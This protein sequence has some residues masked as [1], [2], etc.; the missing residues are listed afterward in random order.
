VQQKSTM[1]QRKLET[2]LSK[3]NLPSMVSFLPCHFVSTFGMPPTFLMLTTNFRTSNLIEKKSKNSI[4]SW[5]VLLSSS[6]L[7]EDKNSDGP[8]RKI[9]DFYP[10]KICLIK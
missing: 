8:I 5:P 3:L 10:S 1:Q 7:K 2:C 4:Q 9:D 6:L